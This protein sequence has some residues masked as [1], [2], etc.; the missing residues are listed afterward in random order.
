MQ[1]RQTKAMSMPTEKFLVNVAG[2]QLAVFRYGEDLS[3]GGEPVLLIHGVTSSNRAF[4]IFADELIKRGKTPFAVDL[5]GRG[6]SNNL[7]GPFGMAQHA[8]DMV[9]VI[10]HFKWNKPDVIGHSMGGFVTAALVGLYPEQVGKVIFADGGIPLPMPPGMSIEQIMPLILGPALARLSMTF[11]SKEAYRDYWRPH[12]A[13]NRGWS[14]ELSEYVD[15]DLRN[16]KPSTNPQAVE[17]DSRDLFGDEIIVKALKSLKEETLFIRAPR[18]L[19]NEEGGLYPLPIL[20]V[21]LA[22]YPKLKLIN[23]DDVNHYDMFL[24]PIGCKQIAEAIYGEAK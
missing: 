18:G 11:E 9:E 5:R 22:Q 14:N 1:E 19:Q 10:N 16:G 21:A 6:D 8:K 3:I 7:P 23:L 12:P 15:Y 24:H 20:E 4:Q 13:F 2:G 17:D